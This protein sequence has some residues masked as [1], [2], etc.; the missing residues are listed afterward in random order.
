MENEL[1]DTDKKYTKTIPDEKETRFL[2]IIGT[3]VSYHDRV[4]LDREQLKWV[5]GVFKKEGKNVGYTGGTYDLLHEGHVKY[6]EA[7][8][9]RCDVLVV[10]VDSNE[11]ARRRKPDIKNRPIVDLQERLLMLSHI[12]SVNILTVLDVNEHQDQLIIDILPDVAVF[13]KG[14]K[15]VTEEKIRKA[16]SQYCGEIVFLEPQATTSTTARIRT[17][18]MDGA[19]GL[20]RVVTNAIES[21]LHPNVEEEKK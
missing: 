7:A 20:G 17:L 1:K 6:L 10:G 8:K 21:Y 16:L 14:T 12:R 11:L 3:E 18:A 13:S 2:N 15:D 19:S 5:I 4:I 9:S